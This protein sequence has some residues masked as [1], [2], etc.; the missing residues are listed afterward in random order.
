MVQNLA[1]A[2]I[3]LALLAVSAVR[4]DEAV[5]LRES[6]PSGYQYH[7][8][9]RVDLT[10]SLALPPEAGKEP[11]KLPVVGESAIEY[12]ERVLTVEGNDVKK[13]ARIYR[14]VE[15]RRKVGDR[16]Q[17]AT[18]RPAVR[19]LVLMRLRQV[20]VPFS[21]DGPLL[22]GEIDLVR[23]DV[24]TP[25]LAGMLPAQAVRPGDRWT[26][27][28][29]AIQELTDLE[30]IEDGKVEC[31]LDQVTV[32]N[33]RRLA[34]VTFSGSVRGLNEDGPNRQILDGYFFFDLESH[35]ISYVSLKGTH[36]LLDKD[37]KEQ[38]RVEGQFV[39]TRQANTSTQDLNDTTLKSVK[40]EPDDDNTRLL[41]E[42]DD[43]GIRFL[44]PRRWRVA[45][46]RGRQL[47]VDETNGSGLMLTLEP[48]AAMPTGAQ[49]LA[50]SRTWLQGQ[51]A[52]IL[53]VT[54]PRALPGANGIES[55]SIEME[56]NGKRATMEYFVIR[57]KLGGITVAAR[58]L[59]NDQAIL[60]RE[61]ESIV[62]SMEVTR[63]ILEAKK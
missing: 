41:Y 14:R 18:I 48:A 44:Y 31:R 37:G 32:L 35:H 3:G 58:L 2:M 10:G 19:R 4:A 29:S 9:S 25:A 51:K 45:G 20:E 13:T 16:P 12:D 54:E 43:L 30:R 22:W 60:R 50:E 46:A 7:V 52:R 56:A 28:E 5:T 63:P 21:P 15:F 53:R 40:L 57:Q 33:R 26:A 61:L 1:R 8:S 62:R 34:R 17:D 23:T 36:V 55:F 38:G 39:L 59:P 11:Q 42:N 24:F 6:F 47:G 49:Y 27:A